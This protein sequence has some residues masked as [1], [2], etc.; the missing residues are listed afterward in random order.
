MSGRD[1]LFDT[2][3]TPQDFAFDE[4]VVG[5]FP[6]MIRRSVPGYE[7]VIEMSAM[8]AARHVPPG[9]LCFDLGSSLGATSLALQTAIRTAHVCIVGVDS[10]PAMIARA[11]ANQ[12]AAAQ[13]TAAARRDDATAPAIE[14]RCADLLDVDCTG[15]HAVLMNF[16]LQFVPPA[17]RLALLT[18]LR[19]QLAPGG[20]LLYAEKLA[21]STHAEPGRSTDDA[22]LPWDEDAHVDF[23]RANG[24][25]EL[26]IAQKRT[27]LEQVMQP[28]TIEQHQARL[29]AAG[30]GWQHCWFRCLNWAAFAARP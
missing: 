7:L 9:G 12:A 21:A 23:K 6:D 26:A 13:S 14:F 28:D 22:V 10:A 8:L 11:R 19:T 18:R 24:Y 16:T 1:Q 2:P 30:F 17:K 4:P 3:R 5:V 25:S 27:A 20:V 29:F 15:A